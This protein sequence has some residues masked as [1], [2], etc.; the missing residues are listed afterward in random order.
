[1]GNMSPPME[2]DVTDAPDRLAGNR[3]ICI[4]SGGTS[5]RWTTLDPSEDDP[6]QS[7]PTRSIIN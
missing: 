6:I 3:E 2:P 4:L 1:M 7:D 5:S